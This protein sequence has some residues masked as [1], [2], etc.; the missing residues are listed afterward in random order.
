MTG[1]ILVLCTANQCRSPMA[2]AFLEAELAARRLEI[3]VNSAGFLAGGVPSPDPVIAVMASVGIDV[4][5]HRSWTVDDKS[6]AAGDLIVGMTRQHVIDLA[7]KFPGA[8]R[9]T[10]TATEL[11]RRGRLVGRPTEKE[12]LRAWAERL[13]ETRTRTDLLGEKVAD[14]VPDPIGGRRKDFEC[15][16]DLLA[17]WAAQL[18][19]LLAGAPPT[20]G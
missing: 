1:T 19:E 9:R 13:S 3:S 17:S 18:V 7:T 11:N 4:S 6:V 12:S 15:V 5:A 16:R 2:A 8:W 20:A 14:D 10:F